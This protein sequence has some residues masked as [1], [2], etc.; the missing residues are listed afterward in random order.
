MPAID[1]AFGT[2]IGRY[3]I[4]RKLGAGGMAE[5]FL[6]RDPRLNRDVAIKVL[7]DALVERPGY[8]VF[9]QREARA[10]A[11]LNHPHIAQVHD[12][13]DYQ[14]RTCFVMEYIE[15]QTLL[16]RLRHGAL[17][18]GEVC[19]LGIQIASA[20]GHA[21]AQGVLHCDLKPGNIFVTTDGAVKVVDFGL[22]R[23]LAGA[24]GGA[25]IG[26]SP[27]LVANRAGT[28][29]YMSPEQYFGRPLDE[30]CDL[31]SLGAVLYELATAARF[32]S[33]A[34]ALALGGG[35]AT[36][37]LLGDAAL[38]AVLRPVLRAQRS[39]RT[40]PIASAPP[41]SCRLRSNGSPERRTGPSPSRAPRQSRRR[42][43]AGAP[44][45][46]GLVVRGVIWSVAVAAGITG[47]GLLNTVVF[48][49]VLDMRDF[50]P[51][52]VADWFTWGLKSLVAP[53]VLATALLIALGLATS[54]VRYICRAWLPGLT[55]RAAG[56]I[57][58]SGLTHPTVL[59]QGVAACRHRRGR[60]HH[61]A[62]QR[63]DCR[64]RGLRRDQ[65]RRPRSVRDL[66]QLTVPRASLLPHVPHH[67]RRADDRGDIITSSS[68]GGG[69]VTSANA[70]ASPPRSR[71]SLSP[72]CCSIIRTGCC[73]RATCSGW[74]RSSRSRATGSATRTTNGSCSV[75]R[76]PFPAIGDSPRTL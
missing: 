14:D 62:I 15:G 37:T 40:R 52:G 31:Y 2:Q 49:T 16:D 70:R 68:S 20:I 7:G 76:H 33:R 73:S 17:P 50:A 23:P 13:V 19:R 36:R 1:L 38:P 26:A 48:N 60:R 66:E 43:I 55:T 9:L 45:W 22:A 72:S 59:G 10:I 41:S 24:G 42:Q 54:V 56:A 69:S 67:R 65:H 51:E 27:T 75:P 57:H 29:D 5:V 63:A 39:R 47:L 3:Q 71:C 12:I 28:P 35:D 46:R 53:G 61:V 64:L 34:P 58:R 44:R 6:A 32:A 18:L 21:H 74:W 11:L 30:R 25:E 8:R 4:V